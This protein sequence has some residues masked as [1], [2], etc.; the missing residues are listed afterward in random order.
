MWGVGVGG[1]VGDEGIQEHN[2]DLR[3]E[4]EESGV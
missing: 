2:R 3:E 1:G 4:G